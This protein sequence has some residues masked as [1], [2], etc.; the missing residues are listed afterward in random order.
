ML[1]SDQSFT[2]SGSDDPLAEFSRHE[3]YRLLG[4]GK[5]PFQ[6]LSVSEC[7]HLCL[8]VAEGDMF[9]CSSFEYVADT[10]DCLLMDIS[11]EDHKLLAD[12][13]RDFYQLE[14]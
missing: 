9:N 11:C 5:I 6:Q 12:K 1:Y 4:V 3:Q 10:S 8:Q 2:P 13:S 7:A 14:G